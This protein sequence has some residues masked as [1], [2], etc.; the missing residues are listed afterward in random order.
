M[1]REWLL[2]PHVAEWWGPAESVGR[3]ATSSTSARARLGSAMIR[4]FVRRLFAD[5]EVTVVQ[6]DPH[7]T[8][9][10]AIRCY[11]RAGFRSV[12]EVGTPHGHA[13]LIRCAPPTMKL[14]DA[15]PKG[16]RQAALTLP[17]F[18]FGEA[19]W[20]KT[21]ALA[22]VESLKGTTV[23]VSDVVVY[24]SAPGGLVPSGAAMSTARLPSE[25]DADFALR[26]RVAATKFIVGSGPSD[27]D[28]WFAL[29][30]PMWKDAA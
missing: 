27:D 15:I 16:L 29:T 10:R 28:A 30:F 21:E 22:V 18:D 6:T 13:L 19:A 1:L 12:A 3:G 17:E 25:G 9:E 2:R 4:A 11:E 8:N 5:P 20:P 14:P 23:A 24:R 26:S 7:P